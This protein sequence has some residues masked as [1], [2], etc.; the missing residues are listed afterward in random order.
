MIGVY[1]IRNVSNGNFYVGSSINI[2]ARFRK[3][4]RDLNLGVH[5]CEPLQRAWL[6][7][8]ADCFRFETI[9]TFFDASMLA[10]AE[11]ALL[12]EHHG[13]S[14]CYNV[15]TASGSAFLARKHTDETKAKLSEAHKGKQHR[16]GHTNSPEHRQKIS[17]AM[18]GKKKSPE[19][20]DKIRQRMI[21][22]SY[23]KGRVV[24]EDMKKRFYKPIVEAVSGTV[25]ESVRDAA[26][27]YGLH[28]SNISR[29]LRNGCAL[30]RGPQAGL[31][32]QYIEK[33]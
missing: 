15:G 23:A 25:F 5:H 9:E 20:A 6:K 16:L 24:T 19:H 27:R 12:K 17:Q 3:H 21:G 2:K 1:R 31:H 26:E 14:V 7:H 4:R 33:G 8:G 11:N 29:A 22:T 18:K 13:T 10:D 32:F 28:H 30:K